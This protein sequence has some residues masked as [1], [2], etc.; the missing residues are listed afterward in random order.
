MRTKPYSLQLLSL[1]LAAA[2]GGCGG[3]GGTA[4]N[5]G[6]TTP[7]TPATPTVPETPV[8]SG[9]MADC[10][11]PALFTAGTTYNF[12]Y[13]DTI[14]GS[15][16]ASRSVKLLA[17]DKGDFEGHANAI[18]VKTQV[19][20][21]VGETALITVLRAYFDKNG[22]ESTM[23]GNESTQTAGG[24]A[25]A[26]SKVVYEPPWVDKLYNLTTPGQSTE[27]NLTMHVTNSGVTKD[28]PFNN[29]YTYLGQEDITVAAGTFA[30][31]CKYTAENPNVGEGT[32]TVWVSKGSGVPL[33]SLYST[34]GDSSELQA[35]SR[36]NGQAI[37]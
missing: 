35:S 30:K 3:G 5:N 12:D 8:A 17:V 6:N 32:L 31:A 23:Y 22:M 37:R 2:L 21:A 29:K 9:V 25:V 19:S 13:L 28:Q 20:V 14:S 15:T 10:Y 24:M 27:V 11:N 36:L 1:L 26:T 16:S 18:A 33:K 4:S 7:S 34:T